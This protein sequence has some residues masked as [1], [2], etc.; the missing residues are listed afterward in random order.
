MTAGALGPRGRG[1]RGPAGAGRPLLGGRRRGRRR[2]RA[3]R[4]R[5][6]PDRG[7]HGARRGGRGALGRLGLR[8]AAPDAVAPRWSP[9][10]ERHARAIAEALEVR[11]PDQRAVRGQ[12]RTGPT[13][14]RPT[15]GPAGPSPSWP[16]P[17]GCRWP[18]WPPGSWS[19]PPWPSC[20][21]RGCCSRRRSR[22]VHV[23]VKEAVLPFNRFPGVDTLL[24]PEMRSTGEVMGIDIDL[25][26]GLRQEP[27]G[28]GQ[29]AARLRAPCSSRWPTGTS[30]PGWR[31]PG[32]SSPWVFD[33]AA[34][35]GT[36]GLLRCR[37][38]R[39]ATVVAKVGE[40]RAWLDAVD[41]IARGKVQLVVNTPRGRGP[42][43][44]GQHIRATAPGPPGAVP[45]H[46]GRGHGRRRRASPTGSATRSSVRSLQEYHR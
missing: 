29:P 46:A 41:L 21:R 7:R 9:M 40:H 43:A 38:R 10:L 36:A 35:S 27:D 26:P 33:L 2:R 42:R 6:G 32:S 34:T 24:G 25:R 18:W 12:G 13:C 45:D 28:R 39:V 20:A 16:R 14:S 30:R 4:H 15:R 5:R 44:D 22:A 37:G 3:R 1:D 23:S 8:A 19:G 31:W 11:G 17:P